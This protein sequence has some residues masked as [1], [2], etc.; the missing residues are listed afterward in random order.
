M[1]TTAIRQ[2]G[3]K[4]TQ[5]ATA[6]RHWTFVPVV[7]IVERA[8]E[9]L[10][11]ADLPGATVDNIDINFERGVLTLHAGVQSRQDENKTNFVLREYGVGDFHRSFEIGEGVDADRIHA[12]FN[13]GVL[14]L[15]LP[16]SEFAKSRKIQIRTK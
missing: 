6:R 14:T 7:D 16:K 8:D 5:P 4:E 10:V 13:R 11:Y 12:E 1:T 9:W 2:P 3:S 15:H